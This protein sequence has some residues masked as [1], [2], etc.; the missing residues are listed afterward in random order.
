MFVVF[1]GQEQQH[2]Q[3]VSNMMLSDD[4]NHIFY[5]WNRGQNWT[6]LV[7]NRKEVDIT[8][9]EYFSLSVQLF[10]RWFSF[11]S[12]DNI[13]HSVVFSKN[14]WVAIF[15][16]I[17]TSISKNVKKNFVFKSNSSESEWIKDCE[18][19]SDGYV[20]IWWKKYLEKIVFPVIV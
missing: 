18:I 11:R 12:V 3:T 4:G 13:D 14:W 9:F 10:D 5:E 15:D 1:N 17:S 20:K 8:G 6:T 19:F 2:F 16:Y 7:F